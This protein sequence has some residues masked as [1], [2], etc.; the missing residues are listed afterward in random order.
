[1]KKITLFVLT[2]LFTTL[3]YSQTYNGKGEVWFLL[4]NHYKINDQ[5]TLGN[6]LHIRRSDGLS[7]MKQFIIRPFVDFKPGESTVYSAGYSFI[8]THP[9]GAFPLD[10][11]KPEHNIWEQVT[12]NQKLGKTAISHRYRMEHRFQGN[13]R[14][15]NPEEFEVDG[16][17]FS[18][19]FRYRL[20]IKQPLVEDYFFN[21]FDELWVSIEDRFN[22]GNLS[23]NWL[24]LGV[25]KNIPKGNVQIAY[26]RQHA[27]GTRIE[28]H[29][30]VQF[31]VQYDF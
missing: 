30:S 19:R 16:Y 18:H 3:S 28:K 25:G 13:L 12:L 29:H 26:L 23:Q 5:W 6:E 9:Y 31:T 10:D 4:L 8:T 21:G 22:S 2:L 24:Y 27:I 7:E 20:T 11:V 17:D 15:T 1:M 14:E